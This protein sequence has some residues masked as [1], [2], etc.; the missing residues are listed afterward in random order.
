MT[1]CYGASRNREFGQRCVESAPMIVYDDMTAKKECG[2]Y[3]T[4][5]SVRFVPKI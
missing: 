1:T 4:A 3:H 5:A 2:R